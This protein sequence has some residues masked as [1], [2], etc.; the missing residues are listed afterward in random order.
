VV[1]MFSRSDPVNSTLACE[2]APGQLV[3]Q[4]SCLIVNS[5]QHS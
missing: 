1:R 4:S 5:S 3:T 2:K